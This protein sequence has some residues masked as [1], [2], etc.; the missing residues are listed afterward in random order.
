M[1]TT[2][3]WADGST[4]TRAQAEAEGLD[5]SNVCLYTDP[6][7][8]G[9]TQ[10]HTQTEGPCCG[11]PNR[12]A[13]TYTV[14]ISWRAVP[15]VRSDVRIYRCVKHRVDPAD[16]DAVRGMFEFDHSD[17]WVIDDVKCEASSAGRRTDIEAA[18][19]APEPGYPG[20][21]AAF[22][23]SES[24]RHRPQSIREAAAAP[25]EGDIHLRSQSDEED[26]IL[27]HFRGSLHDGSNC[28]ACSA[29]QYERRI[30]DRRV[31]ECNAEIGR[32]RTM[33]NSI[34]EGP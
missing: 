4:I 7:E 27:R 19:R 32:L 8:P 13:Y 21:V 23:L 11:I 9:V 34:I 22:V 30:T 31:A 17:R 28:R 2:R 24:E 33:L 5:W 16:L 3:R 6:V 15:S 14:R 1:T 18:L 10:R 29:E 20:G 26:T 25:V 12:S